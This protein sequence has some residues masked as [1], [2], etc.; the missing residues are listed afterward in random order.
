MN[1]QLQDNFSSLATEVFGD[2]PS[3]GKSLLEAKASDLKK[4]QMEQ[5]TQLTQNVSE[6]VTQADSST[7][8][9]TIPVD[10]TVET[11]AK[12]TP[13]EEMVPKANVE[14]EVKRR[15]AEELPNLVQQAVQQALAS[16]Q[17]SRP[18]QTQPQVQSEEPKYKGY[19]KAQLENVINH[20]EAT[21]QDRMFANRGLGVLEAKEDALAE[22]D[23]RQARVQMQSRQ[24]SALAE[25]VRDYPQVYIK[26]SN[27]WNFSDPL[28]QRGMAIYNSDQRLVSF[29]N[30][31]L[32]VAMDRAF[33]QMTRE[34]SSALKKKEV[35][36]NAKER[37]TL[38]TQ[39]QALTQGSQSAP[40]KE[41]NNG[42]KLQKLMADYAKSQDPAI[43]QQI[44]KLKGLIPSNL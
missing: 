11:V 15:L 33:A 23:S 24:Q 30:E 1:K 16:Q 10:T 32:Q 21:E 25:V 14:G 31:G 41:T 7:A 13:A 4:G 27:S 20:A 29:G 9:N 40:S 36:L 44:A 35:A 3:P 6:D 37:Q 18:I 17:G 28:F 38:K 12:Q 5:D 43:F 19:T 39:S 22:F 34:G 8:E 26:E 42:A 2:K